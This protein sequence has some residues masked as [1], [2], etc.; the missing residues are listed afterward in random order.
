MPPAIAHFKPALEA[1]YDKALAIR[2]KDFRAWNNRGGVLVS[3][4]RLEDAIACFN[5]VLEINPDDTK[6]QQNRA[7][8]MKTLRARTLES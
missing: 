2:P 3:L 4:G 1:Q 6:A 5:H 8:L 7:S